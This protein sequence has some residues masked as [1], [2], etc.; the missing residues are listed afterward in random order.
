[1]P[2]ASPHAGRTV[3]LRADS[4]GFSGARAE[5]ADWYTTVAGRTWREALADADPKADGYNIRRAQAG[6]PDDDDVLFARVDG[7]MQIVHRTEIE[8]ETPA[9]PQQA[10]PASGGPKPVDERAVGQLCPACRKFLTEGDQVAVFVLGPGADPHAQA[11]ARSG[12]PYQGVAVEVHWA[13]ATG[14]EL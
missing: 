5:V 1:M 6:L 3:Q 4:F 13:C 7:V 14:Q 8:G 9:Q 12:E 2:D 11:K 10:R